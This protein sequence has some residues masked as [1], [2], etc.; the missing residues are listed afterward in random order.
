MKK[1]KIL[2]QI[3]ETSSNVKLVPD[4]LKSYNDFESQTIVE[5]INEEDLNKN[6]KFII[7]INL[8]QENH[9]HIIINVKEEE[10]TYSTDINYYSTEDVLLPNNVNIS[11][12]DLKINNSL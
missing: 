1:I 11:N 8:H 5:L 10:K 2:G 12:I 9:Y 4:K 6:K 7:N 3:Y